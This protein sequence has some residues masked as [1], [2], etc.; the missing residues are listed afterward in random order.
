MTRVQRLGADADV[1]HYVANDMPPHP[2]RDYCLVRYWLTEGVGTGG[3]LLVETSV[4]HADV[5]LLGG[6]RAN[7]LVSRYLV[8]P[9]PLGGGRSRLTYVSRVDT[10]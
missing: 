6:V 10:M 3:G 2:T 8:E 4:T 9:S 1:V 7:C 5:P